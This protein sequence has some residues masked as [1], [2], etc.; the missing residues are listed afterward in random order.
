MT[1]LESG[2]IGPETKGVEEFLRSL[3]QAQDRMKRLRKRESERY[4]ATRA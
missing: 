3:D 1:D 2:K 4:L